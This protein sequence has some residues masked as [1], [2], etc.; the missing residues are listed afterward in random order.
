M[1]AVRLAVIGAGGRGTGYARYAAEHPEKCKV[2]GVA[3]PRDW[4]RE[5][6]VKRL[7]IPGEH[8]SA[9]LSPLHAA[10]VTA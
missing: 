10:S 1:A 6:L 7:D 2:V 4:Y 8:V 5:N 9:L 3:E